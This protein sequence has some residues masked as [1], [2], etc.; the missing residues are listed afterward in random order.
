MAELRLRPFPHLIVDDFIPA[1]LFER[2]KANYP[3]SESFSEAQLSSRSRFNLMFQDAAFELF[4]SRSDDWRRLKAFLCSDEYRRSLFEAF[5]DTLLREG[6]IIEEGDQFRTK[7]DIAWAGEGYTRSC[8]LDR[9]NHA[10]ASLLYFNSRDEFGGEGGDLLLFGTNLE[11]PYDKFPSPGSVRVDARVEA[12]PNRFVAFINSSN[13]YHG[14]ES[15]QATTGLRKFLYI[16]VDNSSREDMWPQVI[17]ASET[18]RQS[19][20]S[21]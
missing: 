7:F 8:H 20:I 9:R 2:L 5:G 4:L 11:P 14:I 18:R 21:E 10:I 17:V 1:S 16:S 3:D 19:F 6:A 13:A 12:A 15:L